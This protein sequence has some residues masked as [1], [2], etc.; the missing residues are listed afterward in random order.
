MIMSFWLK[1]PHPLRGEERQLIAEHKEA[2]CAQ[3][4]QT[5]QNRCFYGLWL[6]CSLVSLAAEGI[7]A[8][9]IAF[10]FTFV[11]GLIIHIARRLL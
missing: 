10:C 5:G 4:P 9:D 2:A 6:A 11:R 8:D 7:H 3:G 1:G